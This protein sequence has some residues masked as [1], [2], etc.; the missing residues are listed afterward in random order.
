MLQPWNFKF[1]FCKKFCI[2]FA[3][4]LVSLL[5]LWFYLISNRQFSTF[6]LLYN[7]FIADA[8]RK[9]MITY[10]INSCKLMNTYTRGVCTKLPWEQCLI[11]LIFWNSKD[12]NRLFL[13]EE[14][15]QK[16]DIQRTFFY[17]H[18]EKEWTKQDQEI[19]FKTTKPWLNQSL[20]YILC[21][22]T[23]GQLQQHAVAQKEEFKYDCW[24]RQTLKYSLQKNP[25]QIEAEFGV[26]TSARNSRQIKAARPSRCI[27]Q[28]R[29]SHLHMILF[30]S[31]ARSTSRSRP[32]NNLQLKLR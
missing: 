8:Y 1:K 16:V 27:A 2:N 13:N 26:Q 22:W 29:K 24:V 3:N 31:Y 23:F 11:G 10:A 28:V 7:F 5:L 15:R 9:W 30:C 17:N 25:R 4:F 18:A 32:K 6:R 14:S 21:S 19:W 12:I 20:R